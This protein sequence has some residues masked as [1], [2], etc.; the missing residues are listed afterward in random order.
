M[1]SY[2]RIAIFGPTGAGK[3]TLALK[4]SQK[5]G[6]NCYHLDKYF[7][8]ENWEPREK[9]EFQEILKE[10]VNEDNWI[11]DG[12]MISSFELRFEKA[13]LIIYYAPSRLKCIFRILKRTYFDNRKHIDDRAQNCPERL[14]WE[15]FKYMWRYHARVMPIIENLKA[16]YPN[17][18]VKTIKSPF[19]IVI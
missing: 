11:I 17:S 8:K 19:D 14:N 12:S 7:F 2:R 4:L 18:A 13:D 16:K 9:T 15:L 5:L 10:L 1:K 6:L 3:T